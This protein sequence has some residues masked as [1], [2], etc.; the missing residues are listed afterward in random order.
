[1]SLTTAAQFMWL[2][3]HL[4]TIAPL[5]KA[6]PTPA[7][8]NKNAQ[9]PVNILLILADDLGFGDTSVA[10]FTGTG[11]LTPELEKMAARGTVMTNFHS[12]AAT[13]TPTRASI[14]TG[15]YPWRMGIKAVYE[16][17]KKGQSNRD[18]WLPQLPTGAMVFGDKQ[19][20]TGHSGIVSISS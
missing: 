14:L 8:E 9:K 12:A 19:Y 18:D 2:L 3:L 6:L 4:T 20:H 1:M 17:G 7:A 15:L 11:I 10:P 16:Y 5:I 13:C